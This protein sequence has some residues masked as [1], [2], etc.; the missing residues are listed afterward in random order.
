MC[1][2]KTTSCTPAGDITRLNGS[3]TLQKYDTLP[4]KNTTLSLRFLSKVGGV[5]EL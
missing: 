1:T 3:F 5:W 4:Y 2:L